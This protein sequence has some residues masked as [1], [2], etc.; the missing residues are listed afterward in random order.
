MFTSTVS[1]SI[2]STRII[3]PFNAS[4]RSGAIA[5]RSKLAVV[6]VVV[7][8]PFS[9]FPPKDVTFQLCTG[10]FDKVCC[11]QRSICADLAVWPTSV[12]PTAVGAGVFVFVV[13][14][15]VGAKASGLVF[16]SAARSSSFPSS[17]SSR[18][19]AF[20][21][22]FSISKATL[23]LLQMIQRSQI[24]RL[25][26]LRILITI[27]WCAVARGGDGHW[28]S[29]ECVSEPRRSEDEKRFLREGKK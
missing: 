22:S 6:V 14:S 11:N 15:V 8:V 7:P 17:P 10:K 29:F 3:G 16:F 19:K 1:P 27:G 24:F 5:I 20:V 2:L 26:C 23:P 28:W 12:S 13:E 18:S 25:C 9:A 21:S 4:T